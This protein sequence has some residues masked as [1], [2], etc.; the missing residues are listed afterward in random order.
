MKPVTNAAK[1]AATIPIGPANAITASFTAT[2]LEIII[3]P[4][5]PANATLS[6]IAEAVTPATIVDIPAKAKENFPKSVLPIAIKVSNRVLALDIKNLNT[7][8]S[9][10]SPIVTASKPKVSCRFFHITCNPS[11]WIAAISAAVPLS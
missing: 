4:K 6:A 3:A 11:I 7:E 1:A 5:A 2:I 8:S 10:A 9:P